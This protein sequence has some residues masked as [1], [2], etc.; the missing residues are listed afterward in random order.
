MAYCPKCGAEVPA[1]TKFCTKCGAPLGMAVPVAPTPSG[2]TRPT[3]LSDNLGNSFEYAKKLFT[4]LS[5][6]VI[7]IILDLIPLVNWIVM[8]YAARV[9]KE[10]PG[11]DAPPKLEDYGRMFVDGAKIFFASLIYMLIPLILIGAGVGAFILTGITPAQ[12]FVFGGVALVLVGVIVA[13]LMLILLAAGVA[14]MIKSNSFGKAFAFSEILR[15]IARIGWGKY[16]VWIILVAIIAFVVGAGVGSIPYVGWIIS[17]I[18]APP[19]MIFFF[20]SLGILYS[21]GAP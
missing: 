15:L 20:R 5:R 8:G 16:L 17:A 9:L 1:D 10:S 19:L 18:I 4:D 7:L 2:P 13:F 21:E 11:S 14:H 12:M 3:S 6:L